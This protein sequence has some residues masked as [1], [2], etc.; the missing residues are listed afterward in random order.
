MTDLI[1]KVAVELSL[2]E[3]QVH[4]VTKLLFEEECTIPF[5][6]RYRKEKTGE[7]DETVLRQIRDRYEYLKDLEDTKKKYLRIVEEHCNKTP[8]LQ[9]EFPS[10]KAKFEA[11]ETKQALEDLYLPF[12]PKRRTKAG[13]AK[14]KGLE[15]LLH[16]ILEGKTTINDLTEVAR[17]FVNINDDAIEPSLRVKD[18]QDALRGAAD[19]FAEVISENAE[20]RQTV[21]DISRKTGM[22]ASVRIKGDDAEE[23]RDKKKTQ[24]ALK[25]QNY[26]DYKEPISKT[27]SHRIMAV[28]RGEAEGVLKVTLEVDTEAILGNLKMLIL[29]DPGTT[30]TVRNWIEAIIVDSYKRL[31]APAIETEIRLEL[32]KKAE[33][34]AIKV[35]SKNLENLLLLPPIPQKR[36]LGIDPGYRTGCKL[37]VI[38][39]TGKLL[40]YETIYPDFRNVH[41]EKNADPKKAV[42]ERLEKFGVEYVAIGNGT[43]SR[44]TTQLVTEVLKEIDKNGRIRKLVVN[45][46]GAS[47]YST[48]P[49]AIEEFPSLDATI[50]SAVSIA[51]RLQ[52]PLAELVKIDPRSIGVGQYQHDVNVTKLNESLTEVVESCVNHVGVNLNTASYSLLSYVSGINK[53]LARSIVSKRESLGKFSSRE[54]L[55]QV[56]GFGPKAFEQAAG[57]L[58]IPEGTNLLDNSGVHPERYAVVEKIVADLGKPLSEFLGNKDLVSAI[59]LEKYVN[60]EVGMPTLRDIATELVKPGRDPRQEGNRM[61]FSDDVTELEDLKAGMILP[62]TVT[63]VTNFGAFVDIGVHQDGLA[64]IS[65]LSDQFVEDPSKVVSVGQVVTVK[66]LEVDTTRRRIN[67]SFKLTAPTQQK[68]KGQDNQQRAGAQTGSR[69][70]QKGNAPRQ[71]QP[72]GPAKTFTVNDLVAKFNVKK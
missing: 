21:R 55:M 66:V 45:E 11:C 51:R 20:H 53:G 52:D 47:V 5:V 69:G 9:K 41:S 10:L 40:D 3:F 72:K 8:E 2:K 43:G 71:Q 36:V 22:L 34:E 39:E 26:F 49:V 4:N 44:E 59:Q 6:A 50:R 12:K 56:Q 70:H 28:R 35:F 31:I 62:G 38:D 64:H 14:D 58:R 32:K 27:Q 61:F 42:R 1:Q 18:V 29:D 67:L 25:Y 15:P 7:L 63:N 13:V 48:D 57:F 30:D 16:L 65:E 33:E 68:G 54:E 46:S 23:S 19:I 24:T 60:D 37:A 17:K